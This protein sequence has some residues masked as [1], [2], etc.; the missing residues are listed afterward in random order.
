MSWS[1]L[2][3]HNYYVS[4]ITIEIAMFIELLL[5]DL[6]LVTLLLSLILLFIVELLFYS[7]KLNSNGYHSGSASI[8]CSGLLPDAKTIT[9]WFSIL[10]FFGWK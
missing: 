3:A 7:T 4:D 10:L 1:C 8:E 5:S 6:E 9:F 2:I